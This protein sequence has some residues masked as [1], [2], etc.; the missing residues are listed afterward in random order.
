MLCDGGVSKDGGKSGPHG[1]RRAFGAP[2]HEGKTKMAGNDPAI[3][4]L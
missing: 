3:L 2:H 4:Q 1:S